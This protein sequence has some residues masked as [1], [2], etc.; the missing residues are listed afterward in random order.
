MKFDVV[1]GNP[2]Y[3]NDLYI[4]FVILGH[5]LSN[6]CLSMITP[7]K[8]QAKGGVKN[9]AFRQNIVP[10]MKD[11]V[12]Y[13]DTSEVFYKVDS[14]GGI[15][16]YLI[17]KNTHVNKLLRTICR[18]QPLFET[19]G[20]WEICDTSKVLF[21]TKIQGIVNK[22]GTYRQ[23]SCKNNARD[24]KY[25]VAVTNVYS[26]KTCTNKTGSALVTI[27]P[28]IIMSDHKKNVHTT[29]IDSFDT[30]KEAESFVSYLETKFIRFMFLMAKCS[31]H[32]QS[33]FSWKFVPDPG[34]F[35]HIFTDAELYKKYNLTDDEIHIIESV[36]KERKG[37]LKH[38]V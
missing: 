35:D 6:K 27:S 2:P 18:T 24:N 17:D 9:E 28:Y 34:S 12:Y 26:E 11:I 36:I 37:A 23:L 22:L 3:N 32:M 15:S 33:D 16:Y 10:Y 29:F 5:A 14:Q 1:I 25:N 20:T 7:A 30:I 4:D 8:W 19:E 13:P 31:L 21:N 38:E